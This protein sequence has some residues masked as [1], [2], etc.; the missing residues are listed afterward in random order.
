MPLVGRR[1]NAPHIVRT[2]K[3]NTGCAH[4][5]RRTCAMAQNNNLHHS[6]LTKKQQRKSRTF[7][8]GK[9]LLFVR[10]EPFSLRFAIGKSQRTA[11]NER[12]NDEPKRRKRDERIHDNRTGCSCAVKYHR[13]EVDVKKTEQAPVD[14]ADDN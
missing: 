2:Y 10:Y 4:A 1:G 8:N 9:V 13:N 7:H 11:R 3:S 5:I 14:G 12:R 6:N